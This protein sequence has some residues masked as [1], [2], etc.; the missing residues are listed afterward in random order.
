MI[1]SEGPWFDS[2]IDVRVKN[3]CF[4]EI[5][6]VLKEIVHKSFGTQNLIPFFRKNKWVYIMFLKRQRR[7][8]L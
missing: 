2:S 8:K 5:G 1:F 4:S 7:N 6:Q 3:E